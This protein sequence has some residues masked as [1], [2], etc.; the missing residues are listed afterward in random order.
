M[1]LVI[2]RDPGTRVRDIAAELELTE[3]AVQLAV[4][5][6]VADGTCPAP[7]PGAA[8][9]TP[10]IPPGRCPTCP[11]SRSGRCWAWSPP[12]TQPRTHHLTW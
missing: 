9:A 3:R 10:S 6:L 11:A 12:L 1:P 4:A 2:A 5:D 8:P 7:G